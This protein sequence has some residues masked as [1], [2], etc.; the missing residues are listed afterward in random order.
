MKFLLNEQKNQ[1][2]NG[3]A[4]IP[5]RR[6]IPIFSALRTQA[7]LNYKA[8]C[9]SDDSFSAGQMSIRIVFPDGVFKNL[10]IFYQ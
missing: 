4:D 10:I 1:F 3:P 9:R 6:Y 5:G 7:T 8:G 2:V